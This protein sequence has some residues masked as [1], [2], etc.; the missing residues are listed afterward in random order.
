MSDPCP[1]IAPL[2]LEVCAT[3]ADQTLAQGMSVAL[4]RYFENLRNILTSYIN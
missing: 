1:I 2:A 3:Y 4:T